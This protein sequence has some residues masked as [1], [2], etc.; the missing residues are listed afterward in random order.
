MLAHTGCLRTEE[1]RIP[2]TKSISLGS[3]MV[4][5]TVQWYS[6]YTEDTSIL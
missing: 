4:D 2:I 1:G 5:V 3:W 6:G